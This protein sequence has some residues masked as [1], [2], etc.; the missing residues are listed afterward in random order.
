MKGCG[1]LGGRPFP[2]SNGNND[3]EKHFN[4]CGPELRKSSYE[5]HVSTSNG[6]KRKYY[7]TWGQAVRIMPE[8][9]DYEIINLKERIKRKE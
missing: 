8:L 4:I 9:A 6:F 5:L 7:K 1:Q 2:D 3:H